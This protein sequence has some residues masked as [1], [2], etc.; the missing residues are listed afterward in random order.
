MKCADIMT[1]NL[2]SLTTHDSILEAATAMAESGMGFLPICD[3]NRR[4][5]GVVTDRDLTIRVLARGV[6]VPTSTKVTL[7]MS[8]PAVTC[9]EGAD[10]SEAEELMASERKSR[11]VITN[12]DG[13][14]VGILGLADLVE[15]AP[16][17]PVM[18]L[19]KALFWREALGP[20]A[21]AAPGAPLLKDDPAAL[22]PD[23]EGA[24]MHMRATVFTGGHR[25]V[26]TN[27]IFP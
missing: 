19:L 17:R 12:A 15:R 13:Q 10:V 26:E 14:M 2:E 23:P 16:S 20:R 8:A 7:V 1:T 24:E 27:K 4:V 3:D 21:G 9:A 6:G 22:A 11:L 25:Q 18:H 5:V